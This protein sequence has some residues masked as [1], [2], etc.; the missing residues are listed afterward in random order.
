MPNTISNQENQIISFQNRGREKKNDLVAIS[1]LFIES[2]SLNPFSQIA[3]QSFGV[4]SATKFRTTSQITFSGVRK[5]FAVCQGQILV[6]PQQGAGNGA[7]VNV[8]LKPFKQPIKG[9]SVKYFI[10]RGLKKSDFINVGSNPLT[11]AGSE[12]S[13]T[14]LMKYI[15]TD[16]NRFYSNQNIPV[17]EMPVFS[18]AFI[19]YNE[20]PL[21]QPIDSLIDRY[22]FKVSFAEAD[23]VTNE[24]TEPVE[25]AFELPL[26]PRGICFGTVDG[27]I[28]FDVVLND[29]D[30][31]DNNDSDSFSFDLE[32][33][34]SADY[35][36]D[37]DNGTTDLQKKS[38]REFSSL[39]ID[40]AAYYGLHANGLSKLYT[41]DLSDS[42]TSKEDVYGLL[43]GFY[44]KNRVYLTIKSNRGRSYDYYNNYVNPQSGNNN[45]IKIGLV[46]ASLPETI[47]STN[48]W[49]VYYIEY[50]SSI[51]ES[52]L[53]YLKLLNT[54]PNYFPSLY[55][56][57]GK[58]SGNHQNNFIDKYTLTSS[59]NDGYT[60]S[61]VFEFNTVQD[62]SNFKL[63]AGLISIY[64]D[65]N[66]IQY[67]YL[68]TFPNHF[69][70]NHLVFNK[71][72]N[73]V[74]SVSVLANGGNIKK[75]SNN[76]FY[77]ISYENIVEQLTLN[78]NTIIHNK[79]RKQMDPL[80]VNSEF[81]YEDRV[82]FV[83]KAVKQNT[84][85]VTTSQEF[86]LHTAMS[87]NLEAD[88]MFAENYFDS[89]FDDK[90]YYVDYY[91][92]KDANNEEIKLLMLMNK[93]AG[94]I[95]QLCLGITKPEYD[96]L[97]AHLPAGSANVSF[98]SKEDINELPV[99]SLNE[100]SYCKF[101]LGLQ[102][103][104]SVG[105]IQTVFPTIPLYIYSLNLTFFNSKAYSEFEFYAVEKG[106]GDKLLN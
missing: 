15:W 83:S 6:Q 40:P 52:Q 38:I 68:S 89:L 57:V 94:T 104:D 22:F 72:F 29:G 18:P 80:D 16:F 88:E 13:G 19:G 39:F 25:N 21:I 60:N 17:N 32:Y 71:L 2:D 70:R 7:K 78:Q 100:F 56:L 59:V 62:N 64:Y 27:E 8:I 34:R 81:L 43:T 24:I 36:L 75:I 10:Y 26:V 65:V 37:T 82:L 30:F 63:T 69:K 41:N 3:T 99:D 105:S 96:S 101:Q 103:E 14:D 55:C 61:V 42:V 77:L 11:V 46:E 73:D 90:N 106:S 92:I 87:K 98:C 45:N 5:V 54:D 44:T 48:G 1:H 12:T 49:P 84:E 79:G 35:S 23:D 9:L 4:V 33:A 51:T 20:D 53:I 67:P 76:S 31:L 93:K 58:L 74:N 102:F 95:S 47:F 50:S 28:G 86:L 85:V 91:L 66:N 97:L